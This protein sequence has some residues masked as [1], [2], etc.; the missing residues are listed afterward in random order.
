MAYAGDEVLRVDFDRRVMCE[1]HGCKVTTG[2]GLLGYR[3]LRGVTAMTR[4][5]LADTRTGKSDRHDLIGML[6]QSTR[7]AC[8]RRGN[9]RR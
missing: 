4:E 7:A 8:R 6:R 3:E 2:A 9:A 5:V 1:L